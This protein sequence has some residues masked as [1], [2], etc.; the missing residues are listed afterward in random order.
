MNSS[1]SI[2]TRLRMDE[3]GLICGRVGNFPLPH[4]LQTCSGAHPATNSVGTGDFFPES[5]ATGTRE[6]NRPP[7]LV[8]T[9]IML[10]VVP[11]IPHTSLWRSA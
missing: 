10:E 2:V 5:K 7:L 1:V 8:P 6:A 4:L 3:R 11:P 9:L